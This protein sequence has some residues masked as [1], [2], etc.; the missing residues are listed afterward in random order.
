M[1]IRQ[2]RKSSVSIMP[3]FFCGAIGTETQGGGRA[4]PG[5]GRQGTD[6]QRGGRGVRF[7][8]Q[9][10]KRGIGGR[11][12]NRHPGEMSTGRRKTEQGEAKIRPQDGERPG[13]RRVGIEPVPTK[14]H[15]GQRSE[16]GEVG[17]G[18]RHGPG[19]D[20]RRRR[21]PR[22]TGKGRRGDPDRERKEKGETR[23]FWP[24]TPP[25]S[26][27]HAGGEYLGV[28]ANIITQADEAGFELL[29]T[30]RAGVILGPPCASQRAM[31]CQG[32]GGG[33]GRRGGP[34]PGGG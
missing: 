2:A 23:Y 13:E 10:G 32:G 17:G 25:L 19:G 9:E 6:G 11:D 7:G 16:V 1:E 15:G 8:G 4:G 31:R 34:C 30:Q 28:V 22:P 14:D 27:L 26:V 24:R 3:V 5:P 20:S 21:A 12:A 33:E 18:A 29:G